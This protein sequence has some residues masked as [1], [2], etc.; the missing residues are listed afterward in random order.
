MSESSHLLLNYE[1][2]AELQSRDITELHDYWR[3]KLA[4]RAMPRPDD[5][6]PADLPDLQ[7][8]MIT[9]DYSS[10]PVRGRQ[11]PQVA[12]DP[13]PSTFGQLATLSVRSSTSAGAAS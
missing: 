5:I 12:S 9:A 6:D 8:S 3:A 11:M 1:S 4:G 13:F 10:R 7:P 2:A